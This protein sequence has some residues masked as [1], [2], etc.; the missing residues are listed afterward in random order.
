MRQGNCTKYNGKR[1]YLEIKILEAKN[2]NHIIV[3]NLKFMA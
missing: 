3:N 2:E 1:D